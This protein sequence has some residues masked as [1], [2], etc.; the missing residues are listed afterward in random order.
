MTVNGIFDTTIGVLDKVMALRAQK[1]EVISSNIA[2]AETPGYSGIKM[3]FNEALATALNHSDG[4]QLTTHPRHMSGEGIPNMSAGIYVEA[5]SSGIGDRNSV[6][7]EK[8]MA[9]LAEN[10]IRYEAAIRMMNKK[11]NMLKLVIQEKV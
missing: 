10:Q 9:E 6:S 3:D 8:E 1:L 5:D 7:L 4:R 11:F 2:N